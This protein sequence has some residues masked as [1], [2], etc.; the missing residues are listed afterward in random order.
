MWDVNW[1][2]DSNLICIPE[3]LHRHFF[4]WGIDHP[5][6]RKAHHEKSVVVVVVVAFGG[7][8]VLV[9]SRL[10]AFSCFFLVGGG[11]GRGIFTLGPFSVLLGNMRL[12]FNKF[13][14]LGDR[15]KAWLVGESNV[16]SHVQVPKMEEFSPHGYAVWN[17]ALREFSQP[18]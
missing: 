16:A 12:A 18:P 13:Q 5:S 9:S 1:E 11:K 6:K 3:V 7:G 8:P 14:P 10:H 2:S 17:T 4:K 15:P